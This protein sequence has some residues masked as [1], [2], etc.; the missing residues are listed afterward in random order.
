M[1]ISLRLAT[2]TAAI[3]SF[4]AVTTTAPIAQILPGGNQVA[5]YDVVYYSDAS[6]TVEVGRNYGVC[7]GGWGTPVWAGSSQYTSGQQTSFYSQE[8]VGWC[9]ANGETIYH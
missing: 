2:M 8:H 4:A 7:Y 5:L 6:R 3:I 1:K 9:T